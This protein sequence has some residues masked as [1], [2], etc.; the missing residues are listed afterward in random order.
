MKN[1]HNSVN[2]LDISKT[3]HAYFDNISYQKFT[4]LILMAVTTKLDDLYD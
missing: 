2:G 1:L 4:I 3:Y